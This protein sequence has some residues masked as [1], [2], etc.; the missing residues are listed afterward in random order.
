VKKAKALLEFLIA[1]PTAYR[2]GHVP[3]VT[4]FVAGELAEDPALREL[5]YAP[6]S[7]PK[8]GRANVKAAPQFA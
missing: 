4:R 8:T 5:Q 7:R 2:G 1:H 3:S 6:W